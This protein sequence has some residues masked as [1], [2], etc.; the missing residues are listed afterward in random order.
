M[1][2]NFTDFDMT[3]D[4]AIELCGDH[5]MS[6]EEANKKVK[7]GIDDLTPWTM[8]PGSGQDRW[9]HCLETIRNVHGEKAVTKLLKVIEA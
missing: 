4:E 6:A 9:D 5:G 3:E 1:V 7:A 8:T 2:D